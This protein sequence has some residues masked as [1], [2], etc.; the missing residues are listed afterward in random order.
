MRMTRELH[1]LLQ[2]TPENILYDYA[3]QLSCECGRER[4]SVGAG[5]GPQKGCVPKQRGNRT[6]LETHRDAAFACDDDEGCTRHGLA[7]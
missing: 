7:C 3:Q 4:G 2:A 5:F 6:R 1:P